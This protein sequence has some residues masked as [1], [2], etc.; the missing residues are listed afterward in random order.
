MVEEIDQ[1]TS[2]MHQSMQQTIDKQQIRLRAADAM[3]ETLYDL[4]NSN[5]VRHACGPRINEM[6][7][8]LN[9]TKQKYDTL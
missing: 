7:D 3:I 2:Q 9:L 4:I 5:N 6:I 8:R 1:R